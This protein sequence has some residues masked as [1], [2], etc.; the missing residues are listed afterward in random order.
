MFSSLNSLNTERTVNRQILDLEAPGY[1]V[2]EKVLN[3]HIIN[4]NASG[5][6]ALIILVKLMSI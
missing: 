6:W 4:R 3:L 1:A 5:S 2:Q